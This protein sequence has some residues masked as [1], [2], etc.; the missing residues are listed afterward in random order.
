MPQI[1]VVFTLI[2]LLVVILIMGILAAIAIPTFLGQKSKASDAAA[3][4]LVSNAQTTTE[5][6]SFDHNG[7]Y[8]GLSPTVLHSYEVAIP[9]TQ[10]S[11]NGS[12][13]L[14][15]ASAPTPFE[16]TITASS[17]NGDTFTIHRLTSGELQLKCHPASES[18]KGGCPTGTV[19]TE[20]TW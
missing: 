4:E 5:T 12:A 16:Y 2:E 20:G 15:A 18:N 3:K 8:I 9:I 13:W 19:S 7:L 1:R 11:A 10:A 6:Y 14:S 17:S